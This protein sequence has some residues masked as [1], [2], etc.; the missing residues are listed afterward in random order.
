MMVM[1]SLRC[2][3]AFSVVYVGVIGDR[4]VAAADNRRKHLGLDPGGD[5][6][7]KEVASCGHDMSG[8]IFA[9]QDDGSNPVNSH[10]FIE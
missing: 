10:N 3:F 2:L 7:D 5:T 1:P 6:A 4:G 8:V 9:P